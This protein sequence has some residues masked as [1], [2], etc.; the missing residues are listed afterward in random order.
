MINTFAMSVID[1]ENKLKFEL[2]TEELVEK[3]LH[4]IEAHSFPPDEAASM[5]GMKKRASEATGLFLVMKCV[6]EDEVDAY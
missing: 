2:A 4:A 1:L 5:E 3:E 6:D